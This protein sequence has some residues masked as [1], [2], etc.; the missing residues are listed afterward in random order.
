MAVRPTLLIGLTCVLILAL[1]AWIEWNA[2][3]IQIQETKSSVINLASSLLQQAE[4]TIEIADTAVLDLVERLETDGTSSTV[5]AQ[6]DSKLAAQIAAKPRYR[7][8]TAM[9]ANGN[10]LATSLPAKGSTLADRDYF[11]HHRDDPDPGPFLGPPVQ[12]RVTGEWVVTVSRRFRSADGGFGGVV[13][14]VISLSYFVDLFATYDLGENSTIGMVMTNG[15]LLARYPSFEAFVGRDVSKSAVFAALRERPA[16]SFENTGYIDGVRRISGYRQSNRFPLVVIAAMARD[17]ALAAW[18]TDMHVHMLIA[19]T[20]TTASGLL[21]LHLIRQVRRSQIAED[22]VRQSEARY[23]LQAENLREANERVLLATDSGGIGLWEWDV[24]QNTMH[25]D[26]WMYR[27]RGVKEPDKQPLH[28][29]WLEFVHPQ[30]RMRVEQAVRDALDGVRPYDCEFRVVWPDATVHHIH[31]CGQVKRDAAGTAMRMIGANWDVTIQRVEEKQRAII[32]E[33]APN[34][35]MI[36]DEAGTITLANSRVET[37]FEYEPG[38]LIGQ[39]VELLMPDEWCL[40]GSPLRAAFT[41]LDS[42]HLA[43]IERDFSGR[44]RDGS[45]ITIEIMLSPVGTPRG[46]ITVVS[47]IDITAR[48]RQAEEKQFA[49]RRERL[50]VEEANANLDRLARHLVQARDRAEQANRAKSRFL[51]G[52]SHELRTPLNGILGYAQLLH[53]EGGLTAT[54]SVRV[55]AM[56]EA[57]KHLL[58]MITCVLDLS[59]IEAEHFELQAIESDVRPV[60]QACLDLI[61]PAAD[62]KGLVLRITVA[63]DTPRRI[64]TDPMRLRQILLN[65]LGN[66]AK[67]TNQGSIELRLRS[68]AND[69]VLRIEVVDTGSG[70]PP[71]QR[72]RLF[73]EFERLETK[74][75]RATE[76]AGLGLA[77]SS[78]LASL[79]GGALGHDDNPVGGSIFWLEL[80][81]R[82]PT[83]STPEILSKSEELADRPSSP[84]TRK[85]AMHVLVVDDVLMNRDIANSFLQAAGHRVTCAEDG[86]EAVAAVATTD[87]DVVLMDV[88]MPKMDGLEA[89]R[90]IRALSGPRGRVPIVALTAQAFNDQI[91]ACRKAGMDSHLGKPYDM[92]TLLDAVAGVVDFNGGVSVP[93]RPDRPERASAAE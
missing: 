21:G 47:L 60:A 48:K 37:L 31:A 58:E 76:G 92:K 57:G 90:H 65:L 93:P 82:G 88:R 27:L 51:A 3:G 34:G 8:I 43:T 54:Q 5:L 70:I 69:T 71:E 6:I 89:T 66:A 56:L 9:D 44:K 7:A 23:R 55:D 86:T 52:M 87:F 61:R 45:P 17:H 77:L 68:M 50:A 24:S 41:G 39:P 1:Q 63:P 10:F 42:D 36:V 12:G 22:H 33:A 25:W 64:V 13:S 28:N 20:L 67:F 35:M 4:D 49:D 79:M 19:S 2:Y 29:T 16:G 59:E 11:R 72:Q 26:A 85:A 73:Q 74:A 18:R 40:A 38:S 91:D 32:I 83:V 80:P 53:L 15:T 78:R 84:S 81:L 75:T 62:A 30:D 14:A 46:K